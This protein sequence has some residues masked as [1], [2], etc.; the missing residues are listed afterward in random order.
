M[1]EQPIQ[2]PRTQ[3][4]I[5]R[6]G[7][8][9]ALAVGGVFACVVGWF[10]VRGGGAGGAEPEMAPAR[11]R[12]AVAANLRPG[13]GPQIVNSERFHGDMMD[14]KDPRRKIGEFGYLNMDPLEEHRFAFDEPEAW[15][16]LKSGRT[17]HIRADK[18]KLY[19]P[20]QQKQPEAGT[21]SGSVLAELYEARPDGKKPDPKADRPIGTL[22]TNSLTFDTTLYTASTE[23]P[24]VIEGDGGAL[25]ATGLQVVF[26]EVHQRLESLV[27]KQGDHAVLRAM[28]R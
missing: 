20:D 16:F 13:E 24:F 4:T 27:I 18:G 22:H 3:Q 28:E 9:A 6:R 12:P 5:Q 10:V 21:I 26:N 14:K 8:Y 2:R 15:L 11:R 1:P 17:L 19:V 23:D 25:Y 7:T